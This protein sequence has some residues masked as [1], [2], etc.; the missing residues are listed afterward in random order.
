M[1]EPSS[2]EFVAALA[3][4]AGFEFPHDRCEKLAAGLDWLGSEA[5]RL[6]ALDLAGVEPMI[7]FRSGEAIAPNESQRE[8]GDG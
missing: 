7:I 8:A 2:P 4:L 5:R 6:D 3:R 1:P